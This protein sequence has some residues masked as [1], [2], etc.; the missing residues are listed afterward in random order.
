MHPLSIFI[1]LRIV[2]YRVSRLKIV[3]YK[4]TLEHSNNIAH[5]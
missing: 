1:N 2:S 3:I 5:R 4:L